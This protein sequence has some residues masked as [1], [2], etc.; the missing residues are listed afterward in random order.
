MPPYPESKKDM[1]SVNPNKT[2]MPDYSWERLTQSLGCII[3]R[4]LNNED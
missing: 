4:I 1:Q 2:K 3:D